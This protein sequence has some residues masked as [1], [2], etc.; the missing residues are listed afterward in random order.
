MDFN[1]TIKNKIGEFLSLRNFTIIE[2]TKKII[3][4]K[5]DKL[6]LRFVYNSYESDYCYFVKLN[7]EK[8]EYENLIVEK[9]LQI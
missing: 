7:T 6:T 8:V 9:Y 2:D 5:S 3:S 1:T 4:F